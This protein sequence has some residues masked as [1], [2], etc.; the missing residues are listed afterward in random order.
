MFSDTI[1][2]YRG[3]YEVTTAPFD[4]LKYME[5]TQNSF[6]VIDHRVAALHPK[7]IDLFKGKSIFYVHAEEKNKNLFTCQN[8]IDSLIQKD[9]K[10]NQRL[11]AV[12][13]GIVQDIV[14]FTSSIL[15]RGIEWI[16]YPTTLLAQTD[17]CIGSKTSINFGAVKNLLGTFHPPCQIFCCPEVL[18]TLS[19]E[20]IKSGIGEML[21]YLLLENMDGAESLMKEYEKCLESP[22]L[23][24]PYMVKSLKIKKNMIEKDE[25]D[26]G[27]RRVF[28][29]GHTFGH[30][31]EGATEHALAHG[32]AV[33]AGIDISNYIGMRMGTISTE[34]YEKLYSLISPNLPTY[35]LTQS[36]VATYLKLLLKDKKNVGDALVCILPYGIEDIR[37]TILKDKEPIMQYIRD[38]FTLRGCL[39]E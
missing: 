7:F 39:D 12:G 38:Y 17:S 29:Y 36:M 1:S 25:F 15:Y 24:S 23:L 21:H 8:L 5:V 9:F 4:P 20:D 19:L 13:G 35:I 26:Q 2:S 22:H 16:F 6:L 31:L 18:K 34:E 33:T 10:R 14:G 37:L 3:P 11:I 32:N 28:N 30:A 27:P